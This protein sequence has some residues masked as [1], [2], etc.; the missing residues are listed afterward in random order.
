MLATL[1]K[2]EDVVRV[3]PAMY[4]EAS[5]YA[6]FQAKILG[7]IEAEGEVTTAQAKTLTG[8]SRKYLIPLLESLDKR[9]VTVR[10]GEAR[11]AR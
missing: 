10:V 6:N 9:R 5:A 1:A 11:K 8:L 7:F 4:F 2:T 3:T